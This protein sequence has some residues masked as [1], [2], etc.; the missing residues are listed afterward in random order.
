MRIL[1]GVVP[2]L[3]LA[4]CA[5][6]PAPVAPGPVAAAASESPETQCARQ[7]D[8]DPRIK[9]LRMRMVSNY[10]YYQLL[11]PELERRRKAIFEQCMLVNGIGI[12]G[13]VEPIRR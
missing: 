4:G 8:D 1:L 12:P 3:V 6:A 9:D 7:A 11:Q 5:S 13:G 10:Y 2:L